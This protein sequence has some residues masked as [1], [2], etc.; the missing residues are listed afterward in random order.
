[1]KGL[2]KLIVLFLVLIFPT[3]AIAS[4]NAQLDLWKKDPFKGGACG[5][6]ADLIKFKSSRD[7][8]DFTPFN[9][10]S[11]SGYFIANLTGPAGTLVTL[12]GLEDFHTNSG[13][14]VIVKKDD[15][16]VEIEDLEAFTPGQ[17]T[18]VAKDKGGYSA[19]YQP[20]ENFKSLVSSV[21]WGKWWEGST[22]VAS[23]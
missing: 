10:E 9:P 14:L 1:M 22:P 15:S 11:Q 12:Y 17:W 2:K 18:E 6:C 7:Y 16:I 20:H 13:Y 8:S 3:A 21:K 5:H 19:F 4:G 23:N